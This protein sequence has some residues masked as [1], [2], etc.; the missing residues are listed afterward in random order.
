MAIILDTKRDTFDVILSVDSALDVSDE[1]FKQYQE[2]LDESLLRFKLGM[3]PTRFIMRKVLPF[4]LAKKVQNEQLTTGADGK[5]AVQ[6]SFINDEV[7]AS[8]IDI[9]NPSDIPEDQWI[10]YE[11]DKDGTTS[12]GLMEL[13]ISAGLVTELYSA[14]QT[15]LDASNERLKKK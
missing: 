9:K 6:L 2:T 13:L 7:K 11:K 10:K 3:Q 15:K 5:P 8:L 14:R 4:A 1:E 12:T